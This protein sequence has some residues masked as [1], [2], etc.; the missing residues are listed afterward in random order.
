MHDDIAKGDL[1][2]LRPLRDGRSE[3]TEGKRMG[4]NYGAVELHGH[5]WPYTRVI[6][7]TVMK[8]HLSKV[9]RR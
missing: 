7:K 5:G 9:G 6:K 1:R 2:S 4:H 3:D 8:V